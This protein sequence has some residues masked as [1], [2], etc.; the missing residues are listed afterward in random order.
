MDEKKIKESI[1]HYIGQ[2]KLFT[3]QLRNR[4]LSNETKSKPQRIP[5]INRLLPTFTLL[6]LSIG[7]AIF[8]FF[9]I[10]QNDELTTANKGNNEIEEKPVV[11]E[12]L[13]P[14]HLFK[15]LSSHGEQFQKL[16]DDLR[17]ITLTPNS[18]LGILESMNDSIN[19]V[20]IDEKGMV[21]VEFKD[22]R[23]EVSSPSSDLKTA[24]LGILYD[25]IFKYSEVK[26]AQF[27]FDGN[28]TAWQEWT[29][30]SAPMV[31]QYVFDLNTHGKP[32][33]ELEKDLNNLMQDGYKELSFRNTEVLKNSVNGVSINEEGIVVIE[34]KDFRRDFGSLTSNEKGLFLGP[35]SEIV[36]KYPNVNLVYFTFEESFNDWCE[37]LEF[38]YEP[39][40]RYGESL[41][42]GDIST[43]S[44]NFYSL[45]ELAKMTPDELKAIG[46]PNPN[47]FEVKSLV[48]KHSYYKNMYQTLLDGKIIDDEAAAGI[49]I[50]YLEGLKNKDIKVVK[51]YA[52]HSLTMDTDIE[53]L[54]EMYQ[55]IDYSSFSIESIINSE[56]E[57]VT[58]V[59][60]NFKQKDGTSNSSQLYIEF[61][62]SE[63]RINEF[64]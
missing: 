14:S 29:G 57:P 5:L 47:E 11:E 60:L 12:P 2:E 13:D 39:M 53:A 33:T 62:Q 7:A 56:G 42:M 1:E 61:Y 40:N 4:V 34:F 51:K 32:F 50:L 19:G 23:S 54:I 46:Y 17:K 26:S 44:P 58:E 38:T 41:D 27:S 59:N 43:D 55:N 31:R 35:I 6:F 36:F 18:E 25:A 16:E 48:A 49:F 63:I 9:S 8:V 28:L 45:E 37:W 21:L 3:N 30:I 52:Q 20:S 64:L 15:E 10:V 24:F 22:F